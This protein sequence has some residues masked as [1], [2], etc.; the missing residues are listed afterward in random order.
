M[1]NAGDKL[2]N[3]AIVS[4]QLA[5]AYNTLDN[6]IRAIESTGRKA[7][8][9]LLNGRHNLINSEGHIKCFM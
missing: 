1:L 9:N 6:K 3:G 5:R 2:W 8:D 4:E 7:P